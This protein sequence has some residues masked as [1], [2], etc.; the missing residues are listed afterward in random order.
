M[1]A[2]LYT[3][4]KNTS[5]AEQH[6]GFLG[7]HGVTLADG[8]EHS[9]A[10]DLVTRI[11]SARDADRSFPAFETALDNTDIVILKT[12][13]VHLYDATLDEVQV[14]ALNNSTLGV[15][16]PC[17]GHYFESEDVDYAGG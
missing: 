14:L 9:T 8:A 7:A 6:F 15:V 16:E 12:P 1:L 10:G 17:W 4:V 2:C 11:A 3:T 13:A 5:G